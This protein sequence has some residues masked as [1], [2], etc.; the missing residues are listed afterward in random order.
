MG[1]CLM[2]IVTELNWEVWYCEYRQ[3]TWIFWETHKKLQNSSEKW[4]QLCSV[5]QA[6]LY[7]YRLNIA[8]QNVKGTH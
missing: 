8:M 1:Q 6:H 2:S 3:S 7:Y 4:C 5:Q